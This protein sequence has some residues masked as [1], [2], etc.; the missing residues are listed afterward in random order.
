MSPPSISLNL[1]EP[2]IFLRSAKDLEEYDGESEVGSPLGSDSGR[3]QEDQLNQL[4]GVVSLQNDRIP[5]SSKTLKLTFRGISVHVQFSSKSEPCLII[6]DLIKFSSLTQYYLDKI[7]VTHQC[8]IISRTVEIDLIGLSKSSSTSLKAIPFSI[9]LPSSLPPSVDADF[10]SNKYAL[11][12]A[13]DEIKD[14][15]IDAPVR[16]ISRRESP[17][18]YEHDT[19]IRTCL[20]DRI[21]LA[22]K[23]DP[24][25]CIGAEFAVTFSILPLCAERITICSL[26]IH[27]EEATSYGHGVKRSKVVSRKYPLLKLNMGVSLQPILPRNV[28]SKEASKVG[29]DLNENLLSAACLYLEGE[30]SDCKTKNSD[31][32]NHQRAHESL[33]QESGEWNLAY[34]LRAPTCPQFPINPSI[35]THAKSAVHVQHNLVFEVSFGGEVADSSTMLVFTRPLRVLSMWLADPGS[36]LPCYYCSCQQ[37]HPFNLK[38]TWRSIALDNQSRDNSSSS[39]P[40]PDW[41]LRLI[42]VKQ[43]PVSSESLDESGVVQKS[44]QWLDLST[45]A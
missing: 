13:I 10:G 31:R 29:Q 16:I 40:L 19:T 45:K 39:S 25:V 4:R 12:A 33:D 30:A 37:D 20:E 43:A 17:H 1:I 24:E 44:F 7:P 18:P 27:I 32:L 28:L 41:L 11:T 21:R 9:P 23:A 6:S 35:T 38:E 3:R 5:S 14:L 34:N 42:K 2:V 22:W 15:T 36:T 26:Q 8:E